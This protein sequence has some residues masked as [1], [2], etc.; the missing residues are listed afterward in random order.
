MELVDGGARKALAAAVA[1]HDWSLP[2][3]STPRK[4]ARDF[5]RETPPRDNDFNL[6]FPALAELTGG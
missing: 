5:L 2:E 3:Q 6:G 4:L 1:G